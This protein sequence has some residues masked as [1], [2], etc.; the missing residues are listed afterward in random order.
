LWFRDEGEA[1]GHGG[2][3][4]EVR[5]HEFDPMHEAGDSPTNNFVSWP[6]L[7]A[8]PFPAINQLNQTRGQRLQSRSGWQRGQKRLLRPAWK[9][10]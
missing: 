10:G 5:F 7:W 9:I 2:Q 8:K 6:G 4:L 1:L 3:F